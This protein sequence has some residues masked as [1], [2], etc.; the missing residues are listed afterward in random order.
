MDSSVF[1]PQ[2]SPHGLSEGLRSRSSHI[3]F[4]L[5]LRTWQTLSGPPKHRP[6]LTF[7]L[8]L[9]TFPTWGGH[10]PGSQPSGC[11]WLP[12]WPLGFIYL[13]Q[14]HQ[15]EGVNQGSE[16]PCVLGDKRTRNKGRGLCR[17]PEKLPSRAQ[18]RRGSELRRHSFCDLTSSP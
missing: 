9:P 17:A 12:L 13:V 15:R 5:R 2:A 16:K 11:S 14:G 3:G 4:R 6:F 8:H 10:C 7:Q 1:F 18:F